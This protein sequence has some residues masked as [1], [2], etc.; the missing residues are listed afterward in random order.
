AD[1]A[2][3]HRSGRAR[4]GDRLWLLVNLEIWQRIFCEGDDP[5]EVTC[6]IRQD[7][8]RSFYANPLGQDGWPVAVDHGRASAKPAAC[9]GA[10]EAGGNARCW[11]WGGGSSAGRKQAPVA[12]R[13]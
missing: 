9:V 2:D 12:T 3:E 13:T 7:R 8:P 5:D 10:S 4:H 6:L 11:K 1:M